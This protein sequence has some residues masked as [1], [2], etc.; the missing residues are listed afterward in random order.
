M[1]IRDFNCRACDYTWERLVVGNEEPQACPNCESTAI[2]RLP[3][4]VGGYKMNSGGGSTR[5][6]QAGSFKKKEKN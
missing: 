3:S 4:M 5:P 6:R 1:P 2:S